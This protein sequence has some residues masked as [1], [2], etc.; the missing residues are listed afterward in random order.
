MLVLEEINLNMLLIKCWSWSE[1]GRDII[2][3]YKFHFKILYD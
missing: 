3:F 1:Q 2:V